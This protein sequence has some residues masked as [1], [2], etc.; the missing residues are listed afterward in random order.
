VVSSPAAL[1]F[2]TV[3]SLPMYRLL[4]AGATPQA[5]IDTVVALA[6]PPGPP[7]TVDT[8]PAAGASRAAAGAGRAVAG[9]GRAVAAAAGI[10]AMVSAAATKGPV[11]T[12]AG[13]LRLS[14][15]V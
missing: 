15:L 14:L 11:T 12:A 1:T 13:T 4:P 5:V 6:G 7:A 10:P 2:R 3:A 9:A 8:V